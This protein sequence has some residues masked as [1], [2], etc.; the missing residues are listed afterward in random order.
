MR[1]VL[2]TGTGVIGNSQATLDEL[3]D[4]GRSA[5]LPSLPSVAAWLG[6]TERLAARADASAPDRPTFVVVGTIEARKNHLMLLQV[7]QRLVRRFGT[8]APRLLIIGQRGWECEQVFDLLDRGETLREAVIELGDCTDEQL[9]QASLERPRFALPK[10][11]R[12]LRAAPCRG[13]ANG[14]ASHRQRPA[15]IS[16]NWR[17]HSRIFWTRSTA[18]DGNRRSSTMQMT[19]AAL[20]PTS[21]SV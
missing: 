11:D 4:F 1:T 13:L 10:P 7:W 18:R 3:A 8:N 21:S 6:T 12:R 2:T 9:A 16:G 14:N 20:A 19:P 5:G 15:R 17:K